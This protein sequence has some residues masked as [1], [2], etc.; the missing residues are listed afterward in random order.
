MNRNQSYLTII[1][2]CCLFMASGVTVANEGNLTN[3]SPV[4]FFYQDTVTKS[5]ASK[6]AQ[7]L[8]K[9]AK[10]A[11]PKVEAPKV[12]PPKVTPPKVEVPKAN[13]NLFKKIA[14]AFKFRKNSETKEKKRVVAIF[15]SL[16]ISDSIAASAENIQ[17]LI[18]ELSIRENQHYDSLLAIITEIR[19]RKPDL[20]TIPAEPVVTKAK[21]E[22]V[23]TEEPSESKAVTDKDIEDLTNKLLPL[24]T[25]KANEAKNSKEKRVTLSAIRKIKANGSSDVLKFVDSAKGIVKRF[26]LRVKNRAEVYGIHNYIRNGV[27]DDYKFSLL[28]TLLYNSVFIN[29]KTGN[30]KD[31]NGWDTASVIT[32]AQ[33]AGC[34]VVITARIQQGSSTTEF[35]ASH[36]S[37]KAF[38][39]NMIYLLRSRNAK[40]VNIQFDGV[41]ADNEP[42][43]TIFVKFLSQ[44]LKI[45]DS[46]YKV[47]LTI[48]AYEN[49][50]GYN[51]KRIDP[52]VDRYLLN[53]TAI[54]A[55]VMGP[56]APLQG[57]KYSM[58]MI[59]S[60][61][62]NEEIA[63]AKLV[64]SVSYAGTKWAVTPGSKNGRFIQAL[65]YSEI[66]RRYEWPVYYDDESASAVMD[67]LNSIQAPVS[68]IY[69]DDETSLEKKYDYILENGL[70]GVTIDALGY[71]RGYGDLWDALSYK[72]SIVDTVYLKDSIMGKPVNTDLT[73][74]EKASRWLTLFGYV[75]NNPCEVCFENI[76]DTA[77]SRVINRS[78][79]ELRI[80]SLIIAENQTRTMD[81]K[82]RSKFEYVNHVLSGLLGFVT[83]L[84][85]VITLIGLGIYLYN[86]RSESEEWKW[87]KKAEI[88]LI[89]LCV[90][91]V[92]SSFT[93]LF[94]SDVI[95]MFGA[96]PKKTAKV[97][98]MGFSKDVTMAMANAG[99][100]VADTASVVISDVDISFCTIDPNDDCINMPF[101]TLMAIIL[102]GMLIGVLITRYLIMPLLRRNDIP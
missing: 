45:Q 43:F 3:F 85:L 42:S 33:R 102:V 49:T 58:E 55:R 12:T 100:P 27:Y 46:S 69:F 18:D 89:G 54:N 74:F 72:F 66:R 37:Q 73:M 32:A 22:P 84:I 64:P 68:T 5:A 77:Y 47:L 76:P 59:L 87:K 39:D 6:T 78:L 2:V 60:R 9:A 31:L 19:N 86:L 35:L 53:F 8:E 71:D 93:F 56:M 80:D 88:A 23:I 41:N 25:E 1:L 13:A 61:F 16:G 92:L 21:D 91:L 90:V 34:A 52:Y 96:T 7:D 81:K 4:A 29:G 24:I 30:I 99:K 11:I 51:L 40:G 97:E 62:L 67:S 63:P 95:P 20:I 70:G 65:T 101:P 38:V 50:N 83:L 26:T 44:V 15:E 17:L 10:S 36:K 28:T 79:Q 82:Y 98:K 48:P 57:N 75:L 14:D 94:T